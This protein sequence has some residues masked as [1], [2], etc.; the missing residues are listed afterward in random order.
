[1][2]VSRSN[3]PLKLTWKPGDNSQKCS[4]K[5]EETVYVWGLH[6]QSFKIIHIHNNTLSFPAFEV[7][8]Y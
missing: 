7:E 2:K 3:M 1:M 4:L 5:Q 8:K 6:C